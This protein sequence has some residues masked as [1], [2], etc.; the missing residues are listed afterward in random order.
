MDKAGT[1]A[2]VWLVASSVLAQ[3]VG[4][5]VVVVA[6][7]E[8]KLMSRSSVVA[9]VGRGQLVR[10]DD[11]NENYFLVRWKGKSG[12]ILRRDVKP[13]D[14]ALRYFT[15]AIN[16]NADARDYF[17]RAKIWEARG[18]CDSCISDL[19]EAIRLDPGFALAYDNRG[20]VRNRVGDFERAIADCSEAIRIDPKLAGAYNS[21]AWLRATCRGSRYRDGKIAVQHATE[22]CELDEWKYPGYIETLAAAYAEAGD[23]P[24]A[25]KWQEK[26]LSMFPVEWNDDLRSRLQ[27][28]KSG[29]PYRQEP[30]N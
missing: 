14:R 2:V 9:T 28:Y 30:K 13:F 17:A 29:E 3:K 20:E 15:N 8:A 1:F 4:D 27:L 26:A 24:Q 16:R 18:E 11:V 25:I 5:T 23:F 21:I 7:G 6:N 10:V 12:W 22:A 19:N